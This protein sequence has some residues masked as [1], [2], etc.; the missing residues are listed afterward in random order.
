MK[1]PERECVPCRLCGTTEHRRDYFLY[2][3][4]YIYLCYNCTHSI[5]CEGLEKRGV[6][7]DTDNPRN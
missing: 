6:S 3:Q 2:G 5:V 4:N 7:R 1:R